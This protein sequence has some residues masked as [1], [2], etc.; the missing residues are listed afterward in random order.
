MYSERMEFINALALEAGRLT[1]QGYGNC[2]QVPKDVPDGYDIA[3]EYDLRT[4]D[5]I[6][7]RILDEYGEPVLGEE[8]GLIGHRETA[9]RSLWIVDPIDGTFNY[10]RGLPLYGVTV[11]FC[12]DGIPVCGAIF[13]PVLN[14]LFFAVKG[15]GAFL[16]E[17][18]G[19]SARPIG[20]SQERELARLV[21]SL[22]GND[23][24][25][26]LAACADEGIPWRSLRLS[27]CAVASLAEVASGR[28]DLFGDTSLSL[29]DCAAGDILLREA[30]APPCMDFRGVPIFPEYV[31]RRIELDDTAKFS[32]LAVSSP[33]TFE[34][35]IKRLL[36]SAGFGARTELK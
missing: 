22:A 17:G 32:C 7:K 2:S 28:I 18:D 20:V 4:E 23:L 30:G 16:S 14:Q 33:E 36:S 3:T 31:K 27:M 26:L 25:R 35:P 13:L 6:R 8:D 29:W 12:E 24:Y 15:A 21:I 19:L 11:A 9:K 34:E 10:Q 1:L 5:L